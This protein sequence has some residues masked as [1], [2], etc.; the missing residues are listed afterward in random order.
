MID[1]SWLQNIYIDY[2]NLVYGVAVSI[3]KDSQL[4]EDIVHEVFVTL[5]HK[6]S[7][8]RDTNKI[9]PWL[10]R[11]TVNRAIDFTRRRKKLLPLP[12]EFFEQQMHYN[13]WAD[14]A[15]EMDEKELAAEIQIA[16]DTL[17]ADMKALIVLYYYLEIPQKEIAAD[18][19]MALGT[20]KTRLRRARLAMRSHLIS[21]ENASVP[22]VKGGSLDE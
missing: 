14:P 20:V 21:Q 19:G 4:A 10:V 7:H 13:S 3:I 16:I 1:K 8:I 15:A 11:T 6:A 5:Y 2:Q 12:G 18:L 22:S 9:K 17:P